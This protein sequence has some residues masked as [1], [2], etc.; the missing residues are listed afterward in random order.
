MYDARQTLTNARVTRAYTTSR[1]LTSSM[2]TIVSVHRLWLEKDANSLWEGAAKA[3]VFMEYAFQPVETITRANATLHTRE[4]TVMSSS[5]IIAIQT[6]ATM[7]SALPSLMVLLA[8]ALLAMMGF[9]VTTKLIT[10]KGLI[11][12]TG[13]V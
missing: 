4:T 6:R 2:I 5:L 12:R 10:V 1:V 3:R 8:N 11:A 7:A 13:N 9:C